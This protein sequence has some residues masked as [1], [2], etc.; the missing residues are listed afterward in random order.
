[1]WDSEIDAV[2][3]NGNVSGVRLRNVKTG[4]HR[5]MKCSGVF[6]FIGVEPNTEFLPASIRRDDGGHVITDERMR[7]SERSIFAIGALR[8]GY[9]GELTGAAGEAAIAASAAAADLAH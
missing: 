8:S 5:E 9:S 3:G 6:P 4:E 1:V 2:L 7:T